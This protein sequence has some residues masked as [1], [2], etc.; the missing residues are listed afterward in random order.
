MELV[1]G[2]WEGFTRTAPP[3]PPWVVLAVV[4]LAFVAVADGRLWRLTRHPITLVHEAGHA[5]VALACGRR[6]R[7]IRLHSDTSGLT[8]TSG[9]PSGAGMVAT[10]AAGYVAPAFLGLGA[11][12]AV[13]AGYVN[14]TLWV[15]VGLL[16]AVAV[17][18]R[19]VFGAVSVLV[20]G[21]V[22]V[23]VLLRTG[24]VLQ[25]AFAHLL[26]AFLLLAAPRPVLEVWRTRRRRPSVVSDPDQLARL[27]R[28]P[29]ALWV[30][31][32]LA[33]TLGSLVLGTALVLL[34]RL[35]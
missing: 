34:P 25:G 9:R 15:L 33:V 24:P 22:V 23:G 18:V 1:D 4:A 30:V 16:G 17:A 8:L 7:G 21:A 27:T 29:A 3:P 32:F 6:L 19:N 2:I 31:F 5:G 26:V 35:V 20:T 14:A 13:A 28:V 12:A 10:T 11:A